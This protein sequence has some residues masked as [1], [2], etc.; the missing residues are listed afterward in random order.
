MFGMLPSVIYCVIH[1]VAAAAARG[2]KRKKKTIS[3][4]ANCLGVAR[5]IA[6]ICV[7]VAVVMLHIQLDTAV[8]V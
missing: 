7:L 2:D 6:S 4:A 3:K 1:S 5:S 8:C